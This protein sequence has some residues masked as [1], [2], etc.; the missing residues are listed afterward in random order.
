M[1]T[2][3]PEYSA[4][5]GASIVDEFG[6]TAV[7]SLASFAEAQRIAHLLNT[8]PRFPGRALLLANYHRSK[9]NDRNNNVR[10]ANGKTCNRPI[11]GVKQ[12]V[13]NSSKPRGY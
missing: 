6:R 8:S 3:T 1:P 13:I 9:N 10:T 2:F 4:Y 5:L 11:K 7:S 12:P